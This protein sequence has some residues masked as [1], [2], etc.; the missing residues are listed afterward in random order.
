M[1]KANYL[2]KLFI[3]TR[4]FFLGVIVL[5]IIININVNIF[6]SQ[7]REIILREL[8]AK[9]ANNVIVSHFSYRF[10]NNLYLKNIK[11]TQ[12]PRIESS[13]L[14]KYGAQD[15]TIADK[16]LALSIKKV[17]L[18]FSLF[19]LILQKKVLVSEI[20]I[21]ESIINFFYMKFFIF[22]H[23]LNLKN[24]SENLSMV[25]MKISSKNF[26]LIMPGK[27]E[28]LSDFFIKVKKKSVSGSSNIK[29]INTKETKANKSTEKMKSFFFN[30]KGLIQK[31][32]FLLNEL[33]IE[34]ENSYIKLWGDGNLQFLNLNGFGLFNTFAKNHSR[35]KIK[36]GN[37]KKPLAK[38]NKRNDSI[39]KILNPDISIF[40]LQ[41]EI[42]FKHPEIK[43]NNFEF[44]YNNTPI[45]I[46]G[47]FFA[48]QTAGT[49]LKI[50][51]SP[52]TK[53]KNQK[54][55]TL[56]LSGL[57]KKESYIMDG[58]LEILLNSESSYLATDSLNI[59]LSNIAFNF[60]KSCLLKMNLSDLIIKFVTKKNTR[61]IIINNIHAKINDIN[62]RFYIM[63]IKSPLYKGEMNGKIWFNADGEAKKIFSSFS[64][65][66]VEANNFKTLL[67]LFKKIHGTLAGKINFR[68]DDEFNISGLLHMDDCQLKNFNF[69]SW[70]AESFNLPYLLDV[71]FDIAS[72]DFFLNKNGFAI[73]NINLQS[74]NI[75]IDGYYAVDSKNFVTSQISLSFSK[76]LLSSSKKLKPILKMF[77]DENYPLLFDFQ[78]SGKQDSVNF[79]WIDSNIKRKIQS[80]IPNFIEKRIEKKIN[81]MVIESQ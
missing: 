68:L 20:S 31:E 59:T 69:F 1:S 81:K 73:E 44:K 35:K 27:S 53:A 52:K 32:N 60:A 7:G 77:K 79:Q 9:I 47:S 46:Q 80:K 61:K 55:I 13:T 45:K 18:K 40:D 21:N 41:S 22:E 37:I 64:V 76:E 62:E 17:K 42:L 66:N 23:F 43:I 63:E 33:K 49:N 51:F 11:I 5:I 24:M 3:K 54:N 2:Q 58:A 16:N 75:N 36:W 78:L 56:K 29:I 14:P 71:N 57:Q 4:F 72:G 12:N 34:N 50:T 25:N 67:P 39:Y 26:K 28:V 6:L 15:D 8:N 65:N 38:S 10:P 70:I 74:K 30:F 48:D 19:N